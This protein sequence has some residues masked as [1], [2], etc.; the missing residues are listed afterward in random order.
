MVKCHKYFSVLD[1]SWGFECR[2][3]S[4]VNS[5][6]CCDLRQ[7]TSYGI[8]ITLTYSGLCVLRYFEAGIRLCIRLTLS[9]LRTMSYS[10][11]IQVY[12]RIL[13]MF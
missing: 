3:M 2:S 11:G 10:E 6:L 9:L 13:K 12:S 7:R 4:Q 8:L 1:V 5:N